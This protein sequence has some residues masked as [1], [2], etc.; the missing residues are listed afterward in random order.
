MAQDPPQDAP[1]TADP[2]GNL[3]QKP[4]ASLR[5]APDPA[6]S[7]AHARRR[8]YDDPVRPS[9]PQTRPRSALSMRIE[10]VTTDLIPLQPPGPLAS[11]GAQVSSLDYVMVRL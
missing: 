5:P 9:P 7:P 3:G 8:R 4:A 11:A 2:V 1:A 6:R 10:H